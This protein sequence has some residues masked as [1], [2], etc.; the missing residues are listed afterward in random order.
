[1]VK[2]NVEAVKAALEQDKNIP[3]TCQMV[4]R[5]WFGAP[6]AGDRD[7]D[8]DADAN[9]GWAS[10]PASAKVLGD[11]KPPKGAPLYFKNKSGKGFGHRCIS[12][13]AQ[14]GCRSTDM[15][16]GKYAKG[17][18]GNATITQI[19]QQM[20]LEYVGWSRTITGIPIPGLEKKEPAKKATPA[21]KTPSKP[22]P[23]VEKP[24]ADE[25]GVLTAHISMQF[26]DS[27]A[28]KRADAEKIFKELS[29][30][31]F[32]WVTGTE[33]LERATKQALKLAADKYGFAIYFAKGG[34][35]W[36]AV[37]RKVAK[38]GTIKGTTG[39]TIIQGK[40]KVH[41]A[42]KVHTLEFENEEIGHVTVIPVHNVAKIDVAG[43]KKLMTA[44]GR[45]ATKHAAGKKLVFMGTDANVQDKLHDITYDNGF[46]SC[47]DDLKKYPSTGHGTIDAI[48]RWLKDTRVRVVNAVSKDDKEFFLNTDHYFVVC[49]FAVQKL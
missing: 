26:N 13:N 38:K 27:V 18:T 29:E 34:D 46:Q 43:Q 40:A 30:K 7:G 41:A 33:A 25:V 12:R 14:G 17:I 48:C 2:S 10:E 31:G 24:T 4:T 9:D 49:R 42:K 21:K 11:R 37:N 16:D 15:K 1:M 8:R 45:V 5:G 20:G 39:P 35:E 6:S 47:W 28:Q 3:G 36:A 19:E 32:W 22:K 44:V 23:K